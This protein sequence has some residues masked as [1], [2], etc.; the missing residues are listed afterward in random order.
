MSI[1]FAKRIPPVVLVKQAGLFLCRTLCC[2]T[3][4]NPNIIIWNGPRGVQPRCFI[5]T[6]AG[7]SDQISLKAS[8]NSVCT[9]LSVVFL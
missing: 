5:L 2:G 3:S 1:V 9:L 7:H 8:I 6:N 4:S